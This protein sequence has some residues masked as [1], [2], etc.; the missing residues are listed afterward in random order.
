MFFWYSNDLKTSNIFVII[1]TLTQLAYIT[2]FLQ[3]RRAKSTTS[4]LTHVVAK[5]FAGIGV[6]DLLHN[7]AAAY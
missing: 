7:T 1:N 2:T 4:F 3:P 6:L 5:T